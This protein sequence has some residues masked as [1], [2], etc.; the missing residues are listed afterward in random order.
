MDFNFKP[1]KERIFELSEY[2][3][4]IL[5]DSK[6]FKDDKT[7]VIDLKG[8]FAMPGIIEGHG[9]FSGVGTTLQNLN[10]LKS[11]SLGRSNEEFF[12]EKV[13]VAYSKGDLA[14][15]LNLDK[16]IIRVEPLTS[17]VPVLV[18]KY[19]R[20]STLGDRI[21]SGFTI[22]L[23]KVRKAIIEYDNRVK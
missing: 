16:E 7:K 11:K 4:K 15:W 1:I 6:A 2:E 17:G 8:S 19:G 18:Y 13:G 21:S 10:F 20:L 14:V 22:P 12:G 5:N 23:E 3:L 9:H